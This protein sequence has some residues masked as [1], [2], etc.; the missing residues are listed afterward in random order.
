M[1]REGWNSVPQTL[2]PAPVGQEGKEPQDGASRGPREFHSG[3]SQVKTICV[4]RDP[5]YSLKKK[6]KNQTWRE[7]TQEP[8]SSPGYWDGGFSSP[9]DS[10]F[11]KPSLLDTKDV[12]ETQKKKNSLFLKETH[13]SQ[14][15][16][17]LQTMS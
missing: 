8:Q 7:K 15:K 2:G 13:S 10:I 5:Q 3:R 4:Q 1:G 11:S 14:G 9:Q 12:K 17:D 6:K 16:H